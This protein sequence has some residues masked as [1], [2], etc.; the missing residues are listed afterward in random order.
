[1]RRSERWYDNNIQRYRPTRFFRTVL[2]NLVG[3]T[4]RAVRVGK[5][6]RAGL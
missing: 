1:M 2:E 3:T 5:R 6:L 4:K